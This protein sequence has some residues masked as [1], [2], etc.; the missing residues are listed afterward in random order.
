MWSKTGI[1]MPSSSGIMKKRTPH[2]YIKVELKTFPTKIADF[3]PWLVNAIAQRTF[4]GHA[5][6]KREHE[7]I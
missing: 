4:E 2:T 3:T 1:Y 7:A 5:N 6:I